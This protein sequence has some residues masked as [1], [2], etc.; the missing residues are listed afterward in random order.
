MLIARPMLHKN[1]PMTMIIVK[2]LLLVICLA[3]CKAF[4][5]PSSNKAH[6]QSVLRLVPISTFRDQLA[7]LNTDDSNRGKFDKDGL[8]QDGEETYTL[9]VLEESDMSDTAQFIIAAFGADAISL[10][11]D[12]GSLERALLKPSVGLVNAY[13]GLVAYAEVLAGIM[14]RTK[15]RMTDVSPTQL[16]GSREEKLKQAER[17][18]LILV[19]GKVKPGSDWNI[20]VIATV[21]LRLQPTD[22]KIP[23]SFPWLDQIERRLAKLLKNSD[24]AR[25]LQPYLSNLC[26][27]ESYRRKNL[28]KSLVLCLEDIA[29]N[30]WGYDKMY[31]HV[32]LE[33]TAALKLYEKEGYKDAGRRWRPFWAG[34]A[35]EI[36]YFVKK[37]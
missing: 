23:F 17:S 35:A 30:V 21:E 3:P 15:D 22:A 2:L 25:D 12:M 24:E 20:D 27:S 13:S 1:K 26:V 7:F 10:S 29:R 36:G 18:S 16:T 32:D 28:G 14:S 33:N 31:L 4:L 11:Q 8:F 5:P 19:L 37:L 6:V 9:G 34:R